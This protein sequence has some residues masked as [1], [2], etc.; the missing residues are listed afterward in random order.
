MISKA[1]KFQSVDAGLD[2][3]ASF[4]RL[5][6]KPRI[7]VVRAL[8]GNVVDNLN[9]TF[10]VAQWLQ[11]VKYEYPCHLQPDLRRRRRR[12]V[13]PGVGKTD[14]VPDLDALVKQGNSVIVIEH[15][16]LVLS[17]CDWLIELGPGG[18]RDGGEIIAYGS[19]RALRR[20]P[21]SRTGPFLAAGSR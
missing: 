14:S 16:P 21:R 3:G 17:Y 1:A 10:A 11:H 15:D 20:N 18:G 12:R 13:S 7:E 2:T 6:P 8:F 19:P 5:G 4:R 9:H